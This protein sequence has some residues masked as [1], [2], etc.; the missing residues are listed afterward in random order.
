M[1][2][3]RLKRSMRVKSQKTAPSGS[4]GLFFLPLAKVL[5]K[6]WLHY[7]AVLGHGGR[8][9]VSTTWITPFEAFMSGMTTFESSLT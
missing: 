5:A 7:S 3:P 2:D 1:L 4:A 6:E 8:M 9:T